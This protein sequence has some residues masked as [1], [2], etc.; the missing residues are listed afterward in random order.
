MQSAIQPVVSPLFPRELQPSPTQEVWYWYCV[1]LCGTV[2]YCVVQLYCVV[3]CGT[4]W[5]CGGDPGRLTMHSTVFW[6]G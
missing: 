2:W 3:Q 6:P 5:Y 4:V 1:V